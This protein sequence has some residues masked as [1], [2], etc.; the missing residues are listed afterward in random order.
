VRLARLSQARTWCVPPDPEDDMPRRHWRDRS[1]ADDQGAAIELLTGVLTDETEAV[2]CAVR[3]IRRSRAE[4]AGLVIGLS[5]I[6]S[7]LL[8]IVGEQADADPVEVLRAMAPG[9]HAEA[10]AMDAEQ[11]PPLPGSA[12]LESEDPPS[13]LFLVGQSLR[14][15]ATIDSGI[16]HLLSPEDDDDDDALLRQDDALDWPISARRLMWEVLMLTNEAAGYFCG[17]VDWDEAM[18]R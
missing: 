3:T 10:L 16:A 12:M 13:L 15:L 2:C 1:H 9:L 8:R 6:A 11:G 17:E 7:N 5:K 18:G 4:A 14:A